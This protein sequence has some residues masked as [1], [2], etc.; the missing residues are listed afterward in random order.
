MDPDA[1]ANK[2]RNSLSRF[3]MDECKSYCC[4][5]G[6][7][8]VQPDELPIVLNHKD[9]QYKDLIKT[10]SDGSYRMYMGKQDKPCPSLDANYQCEIF[11]HSKRPSVCHEFPLF[12]H[13]TQKIGFASPRCLAVREQKLFPYIK[14]LEMQGYRFLHETEYA[15]MDP[16][17]ILDE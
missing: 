15:D 17:A 12:L 11:T 9:E 6:F 8:P 3:C 16:F 7:L 4:R 5:K 1:I 13:P 14:Q 10:Q 2:A